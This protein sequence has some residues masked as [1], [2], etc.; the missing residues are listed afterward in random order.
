VRAARVSFPSGVRVRR[1]RGGSRFFLP[2]HAPGLGRRRRWPGFR[3]AERSRFFFLPNRAAARVAEC[4]C[5]DSFSF[6]ARVFSRSA[7]PH[8]FPF[9]WVRSSL[10]HG[11]VGYSRCLP[12]RRR[13]CFCSSR[14]PHRRLSVFTLALG[15]AGLSRSAAAFVLCFCPETAL[16]CPD[17]PLRPLGFESS[18]LPQ[19]PPT[20]VRF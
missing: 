2:I 19:P 18:F 13:P 9:H 15:F 6:S 11:S 8:Y 12:R 7:L 17:A 10:S 3:F 5:C 4:V 20:L 1:R 14:K 16:P